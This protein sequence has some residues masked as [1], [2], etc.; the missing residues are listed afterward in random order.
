VSVD[1]HGD[2]VGAVARFVKA[3]GL[4]GEADYLIGSARPLARVWEAW[5]VGSTR[6]TSNPELV[7]HSAL[8]YG[9]GANGKI[10]T[11][12]ASNFQPKEIIHDVGPL[13]TRV[14]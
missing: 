13:L 9:I 1:P 14:D 2:T 5:K 12:Y 6:D 8:I 7:N 3:H 10:Y 11:I 4:T